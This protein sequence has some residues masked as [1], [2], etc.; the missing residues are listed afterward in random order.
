VLLDLLHYH[1]PRAK[2]VLLNVQL[3]ELLDDDRERQPLRLSFDLRKLEL[4]EV[5]AVVVQ[6]DL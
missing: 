4:F 3:L 2:L 5:V 6:R 1:A